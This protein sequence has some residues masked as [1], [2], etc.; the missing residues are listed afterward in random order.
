MTVLSWKSLE[1]VVIGGVTSLQ[2]VLNLT[3][4]EIP[5]RKLKPAFEADPNLPVQRS[6]VWERT[7]AGALPDERTE[8]FTEFTAR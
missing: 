8:D 7:R 5:S 1:S 4:L 2:P 6:E 3:V